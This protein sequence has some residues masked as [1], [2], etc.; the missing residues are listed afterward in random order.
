MTLQKRLRRLVLGKDWRFNFRKEIERS[1]KKRFYDTQSRINAQGDF[2]DWHEL[3]ISSKK[4][5]KF[6]QQSCTL[7]GLK[8]EII[9]LIFAE[10]FEQ[11]K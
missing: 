7:K 3:L 6:M 1:A 4:M 2:D 10:V 9:K 5:L 8:S 11:D